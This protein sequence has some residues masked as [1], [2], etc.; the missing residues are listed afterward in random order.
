MIYEIL[1]RRLD[2]NHVKYDEMK[3][4]W[5]KKNAGFNGEKE[6]YR[7]LTFLD[8]QKYFIFH[9]LRL[10]IG[11]YYF[12]MDFLIITTKFI[13]IIEAKN[14][15]GTLLFD[16]LGQFIRITNDKEEGFR[17]PISQVQ[18]QRRQLI[19]WLEKN[20]FPRVPIE[21]VVVVSKPSSIIKMNTRNSE[22]RRRV[23]PLS[24]LLEFIDNI[25][26]YHRNES[27][28]IK[29]LKKI[30]KQLMKENTP[31]IPNL[32]EKYKLSPKEILTG[33]QCPNCL[34]TP[35]MPRNGTWKCQHCNIYSKNAHIDAIYDYLLLVNPSITNRD[36]R[37]FL[38][39]SSRQKATRILTS[40][41]LSQTGE[42][43]NRFYY[44]PKYEK[45]G[46]KI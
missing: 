45:A 34:I 4:D 1:L 39:I 6:V 33:V 44:L 8:Q 31:F 36:L 16:E 15:A 40:M 9:N 22:V 46:F 43:K 23:I 10:K 38:H 12:Q 7:L 30:N 25:D 19:K 13:L 11:Q 42:N 24:K 17:D 21:Y 3:A 28:S 37:E 14:I 26:R 20:H 32:L 35:M 2:K 29:Q 27:L 5:A 41:N 18:L